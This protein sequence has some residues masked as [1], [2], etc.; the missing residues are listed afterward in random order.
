MDVPEDVEQILK[1][2][3]C[4]VEHDVDHFGM[5]G[6]SGTDGTIARVWRNAAC[7]AD[8]CCVDAG[9]GPEFLLCAPETV[10]GG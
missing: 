3:F 7:V 6:S 10:G 9:Y 5:T 4:R 2:G 1:R 8:A